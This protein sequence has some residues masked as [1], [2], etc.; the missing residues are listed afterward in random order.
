M[1]KRTK[2]IKRTS[3]VMPL[4]VYQKGVELASRDRR[5]FNNYVQVLL[6]RDAIAH[7]TP[8]PEKA[9]VVG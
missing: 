3:I 6:E 5:T 9:E 2:G 7:S 1:K 4:E 8:T